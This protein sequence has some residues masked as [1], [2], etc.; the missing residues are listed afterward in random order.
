M[1]G[2]DAMPML[3]KTQL[4][5]LIKNEYQVQLGEI[6]ST[7]ESLR[8]DRASIEKGQNSVQDCY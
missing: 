6:E 5:D 1:Y 8:T 3:S 4:I 7:I 2:G